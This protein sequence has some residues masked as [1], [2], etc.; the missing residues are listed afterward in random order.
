MLASTP[1]HSIVTSGLLPPSNSSMSAAASSA[2]LSL[3]TCNIKMLV[4]VDEKDKEGSQ[5]LLLVIIFL[6]DH[7]GICSLS[8]DQNK[9]TIGL[10]LHYSVQGASCF[11]L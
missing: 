10:I 1:L 11:R 8:G 4:S 2:V 7:G 3:P 5:E 6:T 9:D